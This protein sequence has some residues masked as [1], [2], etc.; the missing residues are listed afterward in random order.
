MAA[1][2]DA[3]V[4]LPLEEAFDLFCNGRSSY[5]PYWD[6][7]LGYWQA[8]KQEPERVLF[9]HYEELK[10]DPSPQVKRL[11]S[12][13]RVPFTEEEEEKG[14]VEDIINLCSFEKMSNL[15][16]NKI[17]KSPAGMPAQVYFRSGTVGDWTRYLTSE[18]VE[19]LNSI[20]HEKMKGCRL[21]LIL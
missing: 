1:G 20:T 8:S 5:G 9:L 11:A 14:V 15:E 17:G 21:D 13:L 16:V 4:E 12:L 6:S 19:R 2:S 10:Q 3:E 7:V 18:M